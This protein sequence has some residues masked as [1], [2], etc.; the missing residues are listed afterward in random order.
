MADAV[1]V[2]AL[3]LVAVSATAAVAVRDPVRQALVLSVLGV[4][5]AVLFT[6]LQAPDVALS[7]LAVGSALTPLLLLLAVHKVKRRGR[8]E[9]RH[10]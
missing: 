5:L 10:R 9:G 8:K 6:V 4:V 2:V 7:Q 3:L 1:I